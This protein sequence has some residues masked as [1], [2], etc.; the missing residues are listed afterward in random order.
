[1]NDVYMMLHDVLIFYPPIAY[2]IQKER[3]N[4]SEGGAV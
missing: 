4:L 2:Y 1:M 3:M